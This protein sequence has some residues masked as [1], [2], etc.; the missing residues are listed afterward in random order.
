MRRVTCKRDQ[1]KMRE[2]LDRLVTP[3]KRVTSPTCGPLPPCK[4]ALTIVIPKQGSWVSLKLT[5]KQ[6]IRM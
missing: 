1:I 6:P 3:P 2:Y 4:Q 5:N